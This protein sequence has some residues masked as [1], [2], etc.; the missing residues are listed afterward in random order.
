MKPVSFYIVTDTHYFAP[1]LAA[2][3]KC[4]E[5]YMQRELYF[6]KE[7]GDIVHGVFEKIAEDKQTDIVIIPGDLTK[8]GEKESH[9]GF[10]KELEMLKKA[11]KRIF[12][13]TAGHD[14][15]ESPCEYRGDE[16]APVEGTGFDELYELYYGY[17]MSGAL[18]VDEQTHSY[19]AEISEGVRMLALNCDSPANAKGMID[20]RLMSWAK[21]QLDEAKK[22][23][24]FVFAI[25]HYPIIP[26]VPA[27]E[28]VGDAKV[29]N[30]RR[31]A[32]FLADNGVKVAFTGH[33]HIQSV[34]EFYSESG[35]R[36]I[37]VC[38]SVLVGSPAKYRKITVD[39][40]EKMTVESISVTADKDFD[41]RGAAGIIGKIDRALSGSRLKE[42][43]KRI[44]HRVRLGTIAKLLFVKIDPSL[45]KQKLDD[46]VA[47]AGLAI[48]A[49][50]S[51]YTK[52][53]PLYS[54]LERV[55]GRL[56]FILK[57]V[58]PK[59]SKNGAEIN[60]K[61]MVLDTVGDEKKYNDNDTIISL[62]E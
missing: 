33:M 50:D 26:S 2:Y 54:A 46:T 20:E 62:S 39:E 10:I 12:L 3:G 59:I 35:N 28:L 15:N 38:T 44:F 9:R 36:L 19:V 45:K 6:L 55:L 32:S 25:C 24:E 41:A 37:D 1:S 57:K 43:G 49:G 61:E 60:L 21:I 11:G 47:A 27:F 42:I 8:N 23:N 17:G 18:A 58:Q 56:D 34:N 51:P 29:K 30:W 48:F 16:R 22:A 7:S 52:G 14:Y 4:F 40:N 5:E 31:V 53:T 13:I